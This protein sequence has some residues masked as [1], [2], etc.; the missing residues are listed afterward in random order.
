MITYFHM[1]TL[2]FNSKFDIASKQNFDPAPP[3]STHGV[4]GRHGNGVVITA[5]RRCQ[6]HHLTCEG[7]AV[8]QQRSGGLISG[9]AGVLAGV[10]A[11]HASVACQVMGKGEG[12][13][14]ERASKGSLQAPEAGGPGSTLAVS[15]GCP[16][17]PWWGLGVGLGA[18]EGPNGPLIT[19]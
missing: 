2:I 3:T 15:L 17:R 18:A 12:L 19:G 14:G 10:R 13:G 5:R 6:R 4:Y 16:G 9:G 11:R 1:K 8:A 7:S